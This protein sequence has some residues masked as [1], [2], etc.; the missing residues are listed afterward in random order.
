MDRPKYVAV[1]SREFSHSWYYAAWILH[2]H[3]RLAVYEP[4]VVMVSAAYE[5]RSHVY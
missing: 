5:T 2:M 1:V 3:R 4:I